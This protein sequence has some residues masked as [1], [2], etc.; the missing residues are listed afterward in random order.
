M[1]I[2][3]PDMIN[4]SSNNPGKPDFNCS[5]IPSVPEK[6]SNAGIIA[7]GFIAGLLIIGMAI[8]IAYYLV[9]QLRKSS[10]P[11]DT[12]ARP[13]LKLMRMSVTRRI[14][15]P[16]RAFFAPPAYSESTANLNI[17]EY[18]SHLT[19]DPTATQSS[20]YTD[21][22]SL[23]NWPGSHEIPDIGN[24]DNPSPS[25]SMPQAAAQGWHDRNLSTVKQGKRQLRLASM[26]DI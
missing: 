7:A 21:I 18:P 20:V 3:S 1:C 14:T 10:Q 13:N 9:H 2:V 12:P 22:S 25:I 26:E 17:S 11:L 23:T 19:T 24:I 4:F 15:S 16:Y 6:S 8:A 5:L